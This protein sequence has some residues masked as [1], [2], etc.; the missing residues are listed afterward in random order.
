[1]K[2]SLNCCK[3]NQNLNSNKKSVLQNLLNEVLA[4]KKLNDTYNPLWLD[5]QTLDTDTLPPIAL[6]SFLLKAEQNGISFTTERKVT[7]SF[8]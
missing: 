6:H 2:V 7:V 8:A 5:D 3:P 4:E 1:M